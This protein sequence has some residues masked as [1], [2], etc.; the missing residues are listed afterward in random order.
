[1]RR[2]GSSPDVHGLVLDYDFKSIPASYVNSSILGIT[3]CPTF[4]GS[5][6][7][8]NFSVVS[9]PNDSQMPMQSRSRSRVHMP[10]GGISFNHA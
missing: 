1:M 8:L 4:I 3:P 9:S 2:D 5:W 6:G 10:R 7:T